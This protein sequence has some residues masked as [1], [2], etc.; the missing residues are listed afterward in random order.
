VRQTVSQ[1]MALMTASSRGGKDGLASASRQVLQGEVAV[2]PAPAPVANGVGVEP[3]PGS[4]LD[5]GEVGVLVKQQDQFGALAELKADGSA[6]GG[7][8]GLLK[9][10][11]REGGT[12]GRWGTRHGGDPGRTTSVRAIRCPFGL[13]SQGSSTTP[14][15]F[16]KRTT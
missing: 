13:L 6:A 11:G 7:L 8:S 14:E 2:G 9:E 5:V 16:L 10:V 15:L 3:D 12:K 4:G 1:A